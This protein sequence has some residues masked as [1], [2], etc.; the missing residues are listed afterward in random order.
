MHN[1]TKRVEVAQG[2]TS[3]RRTS[4]LVALVAWSSLGLGLSAGLTA[5][6]EA[7]AA[8]AGAEQA[9]DTMQARVLA[10]AACHGTHGQGTDNDYFPRLSGK[11]AGYLYNQL[12]AFRDG[13][14]KYPPMNY[15]L[16]YLPDAYLQK[17]ANHF[18]AERPPFPA[19]ATP[20]VDAATLSLG[21]A[22]VAHG[23][24]ARKIPACSSCHGSSLTGMDP[25]IPGLLG[26][27][28]NYLSAQLGAWRYGTRNAAAPDCMKVVA[29]RLTE[30]DITAV[31]AWLASQ[32]AP[33]DPSPVAAGSLKMPL[34]CGSVPH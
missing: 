32:S 12:L 21:A 20:T 33:A 1:Q 13:R 24:P 15:L 11:P 10:C 7:V 16:A 26:L 29:T 23:D 6:R 27:H 5:S 14:R 30:H 17:I 9:P 3:K 4:I 22:L 28:A 19:P 25:A 18:A 31:A 2:L 8:E 34:E